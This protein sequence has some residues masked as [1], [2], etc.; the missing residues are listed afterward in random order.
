MS[1]T[2]STHRRPAGIL[3]LMSDEHRADVMGYA[4]NAIVRTPCIDRL[5]AGGTVFTSAYTPSPICV[6]MRQCF[7]TGQLPST[8]G[9]RCYGEDLP[10]GAVTFAGQLSAHGWM[11]TACGKLH[12]MGAEQM[13]GWRRRI[14][15]DHMVADRYVS[16]LVPGTIPPE[17][18]G[19]P[20]DW[21]GRK[22]SDAKE[23]RRA[24]IGRGPHT[25]VWDD[26]ATQ[27]FRN[28]VEEYFLDAHYDHEERHRPHLLYLGLNNPH[29]PYLADEPRFSWY[30]NRVQ[31]YLDQQP[32][33]HPWLGKAPFSDGPIAVG[34]Q[35]VVSEREVRR[36]TAAYYANCEYVDDCYARALDALAAVGQDM[37]DWL[38]IVTADHGEMLGEHA[39]WEKQKFFE[40]SVRVPLVLR[41]PRRWPRPQRIDRNVSLCDI[42]ATLC[43]VA[44]VPVPPGRDSRSLVPLL[45][46]T[47]TAWDDEVISEFGREHLMIKQ[48]A[49]KYQW[50]GAQL[51]EVLFDLASDPG[52]SRNA[53]DDP[54]YAAVVASFRQRRKGFRQGS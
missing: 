47:A 39:I 30:L 11:S 18:T 40:G 8:C 14:G 7:A 50:Y 52:E 23:I 24:G 43:D 20:G 53:I 1:A 35:G 12:H 13:H 17:P 32:F 49:L 42:F 29:Y 21:R 2:S 31:P 44:G 19:G 37:D 36:A 51:P 22:W 46:G 28:V 48:G 4:G 16:G 38:V 27:G 45:D 34:T 9:V 10:A 5:A 3:I 6:P 15:M 41:W 54:A 25:H 33:P 26:Y